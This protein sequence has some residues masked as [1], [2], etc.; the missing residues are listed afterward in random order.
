MNNTTNQMQS[1]PANQPQE[2]P[3]G[4]SKKPD[5][6]RACRVNLSLFYDKLRALDMGLNALARA[7]EI[8][9]ASMYRKMKGETQFQLEEVKRMARV[10]Q[11][12]EEETYLIFIAGYLN[13]AA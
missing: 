11:L 6:S 2:Q 9:V 4:A 8:S 3:A 1:Q 5:I 13:D 7:A 12:T 10:M